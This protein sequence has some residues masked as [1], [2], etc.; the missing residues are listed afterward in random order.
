MKMSDLLHFAAEPLWSKEWTTENTPQLVA[1]PCSAESRGQVLATAEALSHHGVKLF[2]AGIWKP[3]TYP[4]QFEGV[5]EKGLPWLTE[6]REKYGMLIGTEVGNSHHVEQA[7]KHG[8]DFVWIGARTTASPF[9]IQEIAETLKGCDLPV[10]LK[11]PLSPSLDL[12]LGALLRLIDAGSKKVAL[13]HRGFDIGTHSS[14]RNTPL[15]ELISEVRQA[16]P[17][18]PIFLDPSHIAGD[19]AYLPKLLQTAYLLQYDGLMLES[20]IT[21][22]K[23]LTDPAQ[24]LTPDELAELLRTTTPSNTAQ[25][26]LLRDQFTTT[27]HQLIDR[28]AYR[29]FLS[30]E[31]AKVKRELS[32]SP[33]QE[34]Q[35]QRRL[36]ELQATAEEYQIPQDLLSHL[37]HLV[38]KDSIEIQRDK[39]TP[40]QH[41]FSTNQHTITL[42]G[43]SFFAY[44]GLLPHEKRVGNTFEVNLTLHFPATEVMESGDLEKGINYAEVYQILQQ[45]MEIATELLETLTYRILQRLGTEFPLLTSATL[46]ITKLAP[47]IPNF[48]GEGVSFSATA[49]YRKA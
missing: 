41:T 40:A 28:F 1:G 11:N 14:L 13:I 26:E 36:Q 17:G 24:Q 16:A 32:L 21:P 42:S 34:E 38:H 31:I 39:E 25:L 3:R 27:D 10:L 46:A 37:Y 19:K 22:T 20:H 7:I 4:G 8:I 2:R 9:A 30:K 35:Y 15:W 23:A 6:V 5:G 44:H 18:I 12:W 47:P 45:E 29:R 43:L 49:H 48:D 33:L